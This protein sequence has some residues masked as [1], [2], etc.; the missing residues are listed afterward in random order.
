ME[1]TSQIY[2]LVD[3]E[4][5]AHVQWLV[6]SPPKAVFY[7]RFEVGKCAC[8][9]YVL[10]SCQGVGFIRVLVHTLGV[11]LL[12]GDELGHRLGVFQIFC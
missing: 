4:L 12:T 5:K 6:S 3:H 11:L 1:Q 7:K 10:L 2:F 9:F 8:F